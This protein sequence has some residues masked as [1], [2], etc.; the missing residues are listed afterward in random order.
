MKRFD[1]LLSLE[2]ISFFYAHQVERV[3]LPVDQLS[4]S[5]AKAEGRQQKRSLR[6]VTL[7]G[8]GGQ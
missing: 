1:P 4:T 8:A 6:P 3:W 2:G 5:T 7:D